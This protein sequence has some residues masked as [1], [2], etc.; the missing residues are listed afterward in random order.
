MK[1]YANSFFHYYKKKKNID[2]FFP[3]RV[4]GIGHILD[5][6]FIIEYFFSVLP[7]LEI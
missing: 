1:L 3:S 4:I 5:Y 2:T 6:T 7:I